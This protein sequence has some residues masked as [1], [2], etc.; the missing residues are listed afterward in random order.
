MVSAVTSLQSYRAVVNEMF[1]DGAVNQGRLVVL[2]AYTLDVCCN[3]SRDLSEQ[4]WRYYINL[5]N[6]ITPVSR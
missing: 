6:G 2:H 3:S 1:K 5:Q 4:I